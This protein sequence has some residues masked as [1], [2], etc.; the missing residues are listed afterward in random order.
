MKRFRTALD[1]KA[2]QARLRT[3][4][5]LRGLSQA[6][7]AR[8]LEVRESTVSTW[9]RTSTWPNGE[10]LARLVVV[11]DVDGHWLLTG[12]GHAKAHEVDVDPIAVSAASRTTALRTLAML[13]AELDSIEQR[14]RA[15][16]DAEVLGAKPTLQG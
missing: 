4:L 12:G 10:M 13:R 8:Q 9:F 1:A 14:F 2:F 15:M 5:D 6:E 16:T 3:A 7:L 11:L